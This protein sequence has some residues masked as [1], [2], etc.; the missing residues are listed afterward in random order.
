MYGKIRAANM[1]F[2]NLSLLTSNL[3]P[4]SSLLSRYWDGHRCEVEGTELKLLGQEVL[5]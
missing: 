5:W 4:L 1:V 3:K 2:S